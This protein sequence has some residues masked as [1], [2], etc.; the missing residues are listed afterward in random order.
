MRTGYRWMPI[1][2][3]ECRL[4]CGGVWIHGYTRVQY[5]VRKIYFHCETNGISRS[6]PACPFN[7]LLYPHCVHIY[8]IYIFSFCYRLTKFKLYGL[9]LWFTFVTM[10]LF[11]DLLGSLGTGLYSFIRKCI[12]KKGQ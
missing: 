8:I 1:D 3:D 5:F 7:I 10:M 6:T 12:S 11:N 2:A 9:R 4:A